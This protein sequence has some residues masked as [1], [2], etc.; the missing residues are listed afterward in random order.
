M[1]SITLRFLA[2]PNTVNF[3][4]KVHG[5]TVMKW[6][7]EAGYACA[8]RWAKRY[9]VTVSVGTIRF[10]RPIMIGDLVEVEARLAYTGATSM[11]ISVEVRAGD[12]KTGQMQVIAECVVV[13][14]AV[15]AD[16]KTIPVEAW[17]P[18]TP[19][20]MA[21]AQNVRAHLQATRAMQPD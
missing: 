12:M 10:Q 5:G 14:V 7:D 18:E 9:C 6:I 1:S 2:E 4:G 8:T 17:L 3:G 19:G 11:N 13:F 21:L 16:G 20:D 15:D